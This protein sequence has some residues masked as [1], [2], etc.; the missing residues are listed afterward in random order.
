MT[1]RRAQ[2][3]LTLGV[4]AL[5]SLAGCDKAEDATGP[6]GPHQGRYLGVG[7]YS[8]GQMWAQM[9]R[10]D[11]PKD[12]AAAVLADD[13]EV[14]VVVDSRTGEIRQ[15]GNLSGYCVGMNPWSKPLAAGQSGPV[16]LSK[17]AAQ[18]DEE[19]RAASQ[20][21]A[22]TVEAKPAPAAKSPAAP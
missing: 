10:H 3:L 15:C 4:L 18:L 1:L 6:G 17:H 5:A 8:P 14:I 16:P 13:D 9:V 11:A 20:E 19:A 7:L 12:P 22:V 21:V 2:I